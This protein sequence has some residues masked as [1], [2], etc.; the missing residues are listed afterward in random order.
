MPCVQLRL[1]L[2]FMYML[3]VRVL[4]RIHNVL[5]VSSSLFSLSPALPPSL[6]PIWPGLSQT[7]LVEETSA[8]P[9]R[10]RLS[11]SSDV[12]VLYYFP[13]CC[14]CT[15]NNGP[16]CTCSMKPVFKHSAASFGGMDL[17]RR[18]SSSNLTAVMSLPRP[19]TFTSSSFSQCKQ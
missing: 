16:S 11:C 10:I 1:P 3:E 5:C 6:I 18:P 15:I 8:P 12:P 13:T 17:N 2:L 19:S 4:S 9:I 7:H 14:R